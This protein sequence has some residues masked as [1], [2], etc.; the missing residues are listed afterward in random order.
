MVQYGH[1]PGVVNNKSQEVVDAFIAHVTTCK[2]G[3]EH[4]VENSGENGIEDSGEDGGK[5]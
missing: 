3:G 1:I 5:I 2:N 4:G